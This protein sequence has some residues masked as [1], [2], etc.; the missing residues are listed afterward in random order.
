MTAKRG[1]VAQAP[2][3]GV[4]GVEDDP[5]AARALGAEGFSKEARE[6]SERRGYEE[7]VAVLDLVA[8]P[9]SRD[10]KPRCPG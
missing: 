7:I 1:G 4:A 2:V 8:A 6:R 5:A 10:Q 9:A 3:R